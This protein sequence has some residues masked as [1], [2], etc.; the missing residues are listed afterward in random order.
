MQARTKDNATPGYDGYCRDR[1]LDRAGRTGRPGAAVPD[2]RR[3]V[4]RGPRPHP[5]RRRV[6]P[7]RH[8]GLRR[9]QV[10]RAAAVRA[11]QRRRRPR[12]GDH[13]RHPRRGPAAD[14]AQGAPVLAGAR[15]GGRSGGRR[16]AGGRCR[17]SP[18]CRCWSTS[19][20]RSCPSARIR[21][22]SSPTATRGT[23]PRRSAT[24]WP[25]SA[26]ARRATRRRSTSRRSSGEFRLED[27]HHAPA[28]FDVE[29]ADP[30]ERRVRPGRSTVAPSSLR[31]RCRPWVGAGAEADVG[32]GDSAGP[33]W[34]PERF[35]E[36]RSP[37]W[38]RSSRSG[39]PGSARCRGWSTSSSWPSRRSTRRAGRRRSPGTTGA[40]AIL[41]AAARRV[42]A[43]AWSADAHPGGDTGRRRA[44]G[45]KLGKAQAPIRVAVTG[46][47]VGPPLF[48]SL[49][50]L[51]PRRGAAAALERLSAARDGGPAGGARTG[52]DR[53]G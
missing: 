14:H 4:D 53:A 19:S 36:A 32:A 44:A 31:R 20:A 39:S 33:P 43:C 25:C 34:P 7:R 47:T 37:R 8:G 21:W 50:V 51:G 38:P 41:A 18:T 29:E 1:G 26:G 12:H 27:V 3:R 6:P 45:R 16:G 15:L 2:A 30:P 17:S 48:E 5:R 40:G 24:T 46:R 49:E 22:R 35:D 9:R 10:D 23:C 42:P 13:P 11:G 28:F 52:C